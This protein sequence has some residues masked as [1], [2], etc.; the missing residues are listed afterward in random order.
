M[1]LSKYLFTTLRSAPA[2]AALASHALML[3][4]GLIQKVASGLYN[5]LPMGLRAFRRV[6]NIIR[7]EMDSSGA[8]ET[9]MPMLVPETLL[10]QSGRWNM[11]K[12]ELFRLHD[13]NTASFAL[14][15]TN[16]ENFSQLARE[17]LRSYK[18][19]PLNVYQIET[20]FRDEIRPRY[21]VMRG[22]QFTMKDAYS[23]HINRASLE[24][25]YAVM[26]EAYKRIFTRM[27][28]D[29][30]HVNAS[31]GAMGGLHSEEFIVKS[32]AGEETIISCP[33][34]GYAGNVET[35]EETIDDHPALQSAA[36]PPRKRVSTPG[37]NTITKVCAQLN[38]DPKLSIKTMVYEVAA[39]DNPA[40]FH[41]LIVIIRGDYTVSETKLETALNGRE[42]RLASAAAIHR[43]FNC[44][45]GYLSP[46][47][48]KTPVPVLADVTLRKLTGGVAG[49][50][51]KDAHF[52][53]V[54]VKRDIGDPLSAA[55]AEYYREA[56]LYQAASGGA[57][58]NCRKT[59]VTL[60]GIE[61]GH[62]FA[63]GDKYTRAFNVSV[64]NEAGKAIT[65]LMGCYGIGLDRCL[66]AVI[67][68]HH[69]AAGI[70][71]P[72]E[73]APVEVL[74]IAVTA[75]QNNNAAALHAACH[76]LYTALL[77]AKINVFWD[78]RKERAGVKF[79]DAD[80]IGAPLQVIISDK[81]LT[82]GAETSLAASAAEACCEVKLRVS[83]TRKLVPLTTAPAYIGQQLAAL[84]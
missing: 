40:A 73:V 28:F 24:E 42:F 83:G 65:P 17:T 5:Y 67:E 23:F 13:R 37:G 30:V 26:R 22:K 79:K 41:P 3:R 68:T 69:D 82:G 25:T 33:A 44:E 16:E 84:N 78:D 7:E 8:L 31:S 14:A 47:D 6:E 76:T 12:D 75:K 18:Q 57:C 46:I 19:L 51:E 11:F 80:L 21:G 32:A 45:Q 53:N 4:A 39:A 81:L 1:R 52:I 74:L 59:L 49:A 50:N 10:K 36:C 35:A 43:V 71:F 38:V 70:C 55:G 72:R 34:C 66:A 60:K 56:S 2:E 58:C 48:L 77:A 20:K 29:F 62:I 63:L 27:D 15:P 9:A 64:L 54:D 61:V